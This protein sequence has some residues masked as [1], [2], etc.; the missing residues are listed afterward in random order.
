M[1]VMITGG[2]GFVGFHSARKL[3]AAGHEVVLLVRD[4]NKVAKLYPQQQ[5]DYVQGDITDVASVRDALR[6]CDGAI[7][8]AA[9]VSTDAKDAER[10]Y[11]TNVDGTRTLLTEAY[12]AGLKSIVHVSSITAL[13]DQKATMLDGQSPP[14][15]ARNAYGRSKVDCEKF[16]RELQAQGAPLHIT[17][18]SSVIG[19]DDPGL[20][21]PHIGMRT[22][23]SAF[24]PLMPGGNQF[25]D[26]RDVA[27]VHLRLLTAEIPAGRFT[28]G[29][30]FLSWR[31]LARCLEQTTNRKLIKVPASGFFMRSL[32]RSVDWMKRFRHFDAPM[33]YEAMVYATRWVPMSN[34]DVEKTLDFSFR[35]LP[36]SLHDCIRWLYEEGYVTARQAGAVAND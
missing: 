22:Y 27:E 24:I 30:H 1:R 31:E 29:G 36:E 3:M 6:D 12:N 32:G 16:A 21:E 25:V 2:T 5:P 19:P 35:P 13:F 17:Y 11:Q 18:P 7:H 8:C 33:G 9:M 15:N 10:V 26:V 23:L 14:G 28:L 34:T 20:T 4:P